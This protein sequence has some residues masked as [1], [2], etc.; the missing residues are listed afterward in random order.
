MSSHSCTADTLLPTE[1][2]VDVTLGDESSP[3][4]YDRAAVYMDA[5]CTQCKRT[6]QLNTIPGFINEFDVLVFEQGEIRQAGSG[7]GACFELS[8]HNVVDSVRLLLDTAMHAPQLANPEAEF[9]VTSVR[10]YCAFGQT[11]EQPQIENTRVIV[12]STEAWI[13]YAAGHGRHLFSDPDVT[14]SHLTVL[15]FSALSSYE[16]S[17]VNS[18]MTTLATA[19]CL[20]LTLTMSDIVTWKEEASTAPELNLD[21]VSY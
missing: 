19:M 6:M 7:D 8:H 13:S 20:E 1:I 15:D 12:G 14:L 2:F 5:M 3:S 18:C 11:L 4:I 10:Y 17:P 9:K 21:A 16:V